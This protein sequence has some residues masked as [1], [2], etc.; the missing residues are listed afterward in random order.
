MNHT[1]HLV[2]EY[3]NRELHVFPPFELF[4]NAFQILSSFLIKLKRVINFKNQIS[5]HYFITIT[6]AYS[7]IGDSWSDS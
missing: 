5:F 3:A 7:G 6:N 4:D 2:L 1:I